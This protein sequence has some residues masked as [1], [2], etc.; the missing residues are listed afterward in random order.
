M[1]VSAELLNEIEIYVR[2]YEEKTNV[3][4]G[5]S[6][7]KK[8]MIEK[9][10]ADA[11]VK[12]FLKWKQRE[13]LIKE[14]Q[15]KILYQEKTLKDI[16]NGNDIG[17]ICSQTKSE[18][19]LV[20]KSRDTYKDMYEKKV[21]KIILLEKQLKSNRSDRATLLR[22]KEKEK[23]YQG[24]LNII[25]DLRNKIKEIEYKELEYDNLNFKYEK[26]SKE[27]AE[28]DS[29]YNDDGIIKGSWGIS[30]E[31]KYGSFHED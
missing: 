30:D 23:E 10:E 1:E 16:N 29:L 28:R 24:K 17:I 27:F 26:L 18:L 13:D 25:N 21:K 7:L 15:M 19:F 31:E 4:A 2:D 9:G 3:D 12:R 6:K 14:Q 22:A 5:K 8:A 11:S 20:K